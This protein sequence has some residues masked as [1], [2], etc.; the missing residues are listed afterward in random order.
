MRISAVVGHR[1]KL[2]TVA[3]STEQFARLQL[4]GK[5]GQRHRR[6]Q[7]RMPDFP[8]CFNPLGYPNVPKGLELVAGGFS[9]TLL[10]CLP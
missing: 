7:I 6:C 2:L 9:Q 3:I 5:V 4:G 10:Q 8:Q 1:A